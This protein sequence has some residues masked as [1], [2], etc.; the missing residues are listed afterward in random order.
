MYRLVLVV[1]YWTVMPEIPIIKFLMLIFFI[2]HLLL[3]LLSSSAPTQLR[4]AAMQG[5]A[6]T[7]A[8]LNT[9]N[10][11]PKKDGGFKS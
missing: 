10:N 2:I 4:T 5:P 8:Q 6:W 11:P 1:C 9:N 3:P 7:A